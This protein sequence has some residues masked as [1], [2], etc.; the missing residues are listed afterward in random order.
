MTQRDLPSLGIIMLDT[1]FERP[2]G[3]VGN[4]RT[5][6]FPTLYQTVRGATARKVVSG[7]DSDL[8]EGFVAAAEALTEKGAVG[9]I[10]SCGFLAAHQGALAARMKLPLATSSLLQVP[11]VARCLSG[12]KRV[13]VVTY[14]ADALGPHH[15]AA[16]GAATDTSVVGLPSRG[17]LHAVIE[18]GEKLSPDIAEQEVV[19]SVR[20]LMSDYSDIGAIVFE[21]TNLPPYSAAVRQAFGVPVFDIVTMGIWFYR[22]LIERH[23]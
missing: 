4:T 20:Q 14:D 23:F 15:L 21:C 7:D 1:S 8:L 12:G 17:H 11:I 10:T 16:A 22:G 9:L 13:G 5:W 18:R 19:E 2:P 3:D 6:P